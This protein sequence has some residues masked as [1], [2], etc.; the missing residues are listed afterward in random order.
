MK[1]T[2]LFLL[3]LIAQSAMSYIQVRKCE[4]KSE[5]RQQV[6]D[7]RESMKSM[8]NDL[9]EYK[10]TTNLEKK[11]RRKV[12]QAI[13]VLRCSILR[14]KATRIKCVENDNGAIAYTYAVI[15]KTIWLT[16]KFD[17]YSRNDKLGIFIHEYTHKCGTNDADYFWTRPPSDIQ[18]KKW[19]SIADTYRYWHVNGV[20]IPEL[21]C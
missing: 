2:I 8:I 10:E 5:I 7:S 3:I 19:S 20:C 14:S 4:D 21:D 15:G 1:F 16:E 13:R 12:N 6:R 9:R 17:E 18:K 11:V